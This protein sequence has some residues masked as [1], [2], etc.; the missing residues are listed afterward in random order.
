VAQPLEPVVLVLTGAENPYR[1]LRW[2]RRGPAVRLLGRL[3]LG[4]GALNH[5]SLDL[6]PQRAATAYVRGLLV[7]AG[8]LPPRDENLALLTNW[9]AR[10]VADLPA[11]YANL[12]RPFAEGHIIRDARRRSARGRYTYAAHKGDC[13]NVAAA[14]DFLNRLDSPYLSLRRLQQPHLDAW[15]TDRPTLRT[16]SIPFLRWSTARRLC[17][18]RLIIEHPA[19]Q[20]P[21]ALRRSGRWA[22]VVELLA[23]Y[24]RTTRGLLADYSR[25]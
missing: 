3:A 21:S 11:R 5:E 18:P 20:K 9:I 7:T 22:S 13:S 6:L 25:T 17:P 15:A 8:I 23:D 16:C 2:L 10:T 19:S 4:P 12:I 14:I 1:I 24:S